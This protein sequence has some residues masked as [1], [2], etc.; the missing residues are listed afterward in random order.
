MKN[1]NPGIG[2]VWYVV[3]P[4]GSAVFAAALGVALGLATRH[5]GLAFALAPLLVAL[6]WS[7][8]RLYTAPPI[9]VFDPLFGYFAGSVYD[10]RVTVPTALLWA[11]AYHLAI[12]LALLATC[13]V[14][15]D[16]DTLSLRWRSRRRPLLALTFVVAAAGLYASGPVLGYRE[17][18]R[19]IARALGGTRSTRHFVLH[20]AEAGPYAHELD[21]VA[22]ELEFRWS[23]LAEMLATSH[24]SPYTRTSS[25]ALRRSRRSWAPG[26]RTSQNR[27]VARSTSITSRFRSRSWGTSSPTSS[28]P[29]S[30]T[31]CSACRDTACVSTSASRK[32]SRRRSP[33]RAH[34]SRPTSPRPSSSSC[35]A[36]RRSTP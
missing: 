24:R 35:T 4:L 12:A 7:V 32:A 29:T 17:D 9:F 31:V 22:R 6:V 28:A 18:A 20:Y 11:R 8:W 36:C 10:E 19:S 15:L 34:R 27:G 3:L 1:C 13:A 26:T 2:L 33:G 16:G 5:R 30:A 23:E 21:D 14:F 25:P